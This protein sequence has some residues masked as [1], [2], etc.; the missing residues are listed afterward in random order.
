MDITRKISITTKALVLDMVAKI[1]SGH[2]GMPLGF[3]DVAANLM[4]HH[5][6]FDT[7]NPKHPLR[8]RLILSAGHGSALLY[9]LFYIFSFKNFKLEALEFFRR[10]EGIAAGHPESSLYPHIETTTGPLGQGVGVGVG[11]AIFAKKYQEKMLANVTNK[12]ERR[13][14]KKALDYKIYVIAG[15]GCLMEGISYEAL[16]LAGH[17]NLNNLI[18]LF[19]DNN[20]TIDGVTDISISENK[21]KIYEAFGFNIFK[22]NG[23]DSDE[24]NEAISSAKKS[25]KPSIIFFKT[26][27]GNGLKN[28]EGLAKAHGAGVSKEEVKEFKAQHNLPEQYLY[29]DP[30]LIKKLKVHTSNLQKNLQNRLDIVGEQPEFNIKPEDILEQYKDKAVTDVPI[31]SREMVGRIVKELATSDQVIIGSADLG[32]STCMISENTKAITR[33]DFSGNYINFGAREHAMAA[34]ANG[35]AEEGMLPIISTFLVFSDYLRP[36]LRLSALM[37]QKVIYVFTHDSILI[38]EDGPTH[39]PVEHLWSL[40]LIPNLYVYRPCTFEET[41]F[42][43]KDSVLN[44]R[45]AA[46]LA[47]RQPLLLIPDYDSSE[48]E[49]GGY[50]VSKKKH[51]DP[52]VTI[53][54]SGSEVAPAA[55]AEL[56]LECFRVK[57]NV[58]SC[59][60]Y[61]KF[62]S[63]NFDYKEEL[64]KGFIVVFEAQNS[65]TIDSMLHKC[66]KITQ[67][68]FGI[69]ERSGG[70]ERVFNLNSDFVINEVMTSIDYWNTYGFDESTQESEE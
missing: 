51:I 54:A 29:V 60:C 7:Q 26:K 66:M 9:S 30:N 47:S 10:K 5:L 49:K 55:R 25:T 19:D 12:D 65:N 15:D 34:I 61:K 1:N 58:I 64:K 42:S 62:L 31:S 35:L 70:L 18:I 57:T 2:I 68:K 67:T 39:Q 46:I 36:A 22:A 23:H 6:N 41:L 69:S 17:L 13:K 4:Y 27:I 32:V 44:Q 59:F 52:G 53:I 24:I 56:N 21:E 16:S 48:V 37:K 28:Y 45:P 3:A 11:R 8:D 20:T 14:I 33:D 43:M 63:Q 50:I 38:G 40:N